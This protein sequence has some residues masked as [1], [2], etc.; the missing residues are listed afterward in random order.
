MLNSVVED[1]FASVVGVD[2][3]TMHLDRGTGIPTVKIDASFA[4]VS[5]LGD[6]LAFALSLCRVGTSSAEFRLRVECA[7]ETRFLANLVLVCM[8]LE[9]ARAMPW[10]DDLRPKRLM[11]VGV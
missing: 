5:R 1:Y 2:F 6:D 4:A 8:D 9:K 7:G 3:A 11:A 10:P